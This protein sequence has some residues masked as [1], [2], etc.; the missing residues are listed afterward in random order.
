MSVASKRLNGPA[1]GRHGHPHDHRGGQPTARA[2]FLD[3]KKLTPAAPICRDRIRMS[4]LKRFPSLIGDIYEAI[5][6]KSVWSDVLGNVAQFVGAQA[7]ALL[8]RSAS[9]SIDD[10]H[11]FGIKSPSLE[12]YK[13]H[14]A[15][16]DPTTKPLLLR[17]VGEV[18]STTDIISYSEYVES[19]FYTEWVKPQGF[20]DSWQA[21]LDKSVP[22]S[23]HL[24]FW[25]NSKNGSESDA[26]RDRMRFI[27]P[28]LRRVVLISNLVDHGKAEAA[29]F[30]DTL[31]GIAAG[32]FL[33]D[34][35][36]RILHANAS[37][38]A[39][40]ARGVVLRAYGGKLVSHDASAEQELYSVLGAVGAG[41]VAPGTH[42]VAVPLT[43]RHGDR[44]V[45]HVLP[46]TSGM[47]RR[48]GAGYAA[49]AAVF[50]QKA[51]LDVPPPQEAIAKLYKLTPMELR[52]LFAIVQ[53][54]GVPEVAAMMGSSGSTIR[55]HLRRLFSKTGTDR[56]A[57][58]VKLVA[59]YTNPLLPNARVFE[60]PHT[61]GGRGVPAAKLESSG[62]DGRSSDVAC[63]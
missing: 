1:D 31:D 6:D 9:Q 32:L 10:I 57:D 50:V 53:V 61:I 2:V 54:G 19:R 14:Y 35:N 40:L 51:L 34:A 25:R 48:A 4:E 24:I 18:A 52:V 28:H 47:R 5:L 3:H 12:T 63:L 45:A 55:T 44:Y 16:L 30:G 8:W 60:H 23:V 22:T 58:L 36:G 26:T 7:G 37:G 42:T 33:V 21:S 17:D 20:V 27:V 46:L 13:E 29:L 56:Q 62:L 15:N 59:G 39:L 43:T 41:Q 49:A 11:T 38:Q